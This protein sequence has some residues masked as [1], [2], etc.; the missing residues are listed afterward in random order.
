MTAYIR[1]LDGA[2]M[3]PLASHTYVN[4]AFAMREPMPIDG[5]H[6][7]PQRVAAMTAEAAHGDEMA[8][9]A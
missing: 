4:A 1:T 5:R 2:T 6:L 7:T 3:V 9:A 8:E